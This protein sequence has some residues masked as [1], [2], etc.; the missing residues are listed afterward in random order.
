[1]LY[2]AE[3]SA[4]PRQ[5]SGSIMCRAKNSEHLVVKCCEIVHDT[6]L[7]ECPEPDEDRIP[8]FLAMS[9][10]VNKIASRFYKWYYH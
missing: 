4:M 5:K 1:M 10:H 3:K 6:I 9:S 7:F 8:V 2:H